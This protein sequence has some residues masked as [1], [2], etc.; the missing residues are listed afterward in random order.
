MPDRWLDTVTCP[1]CGVG[2]VT[3]ML[4]KKFICCK[5]CC[6]WW[7]FGQEF[8]RLRYIRRSY[9]PLAWRIVAE[10][11]AGVVFRKIVRETLEKGIG[12]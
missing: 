3:T 7:D 4:N 5:K 2:G 12:D 9:L 1:K 6:I 11:M 10:E 8:E